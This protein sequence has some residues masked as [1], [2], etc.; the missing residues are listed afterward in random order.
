M[1]RRDQRDRANHPLHR[2][3]LLKYAVAVL[4]AAVVCI[5]N[6]RMQQRRI[7]ASLFIALAFTILLIRYLPPRVALHDIGDP[8]DQQVLSGFRAAEPIDG[9]LGRRTNGPA[10]I[11][12]PLADGRGAARMALQLRSGAASTDRVQLRFGATPLTV[13][14]PPT[15]RTLYLALPPRAARTFD[16]ELR[17]VPGAPPLDVLVDRVIVWGRGGVPPAL[18]LVALALIALVPGLGVALAARLSLDWALLPGVITIA[19]ALALPAADR[20]ALLLFGPFFTVVVAIAAVLPLPRA[21]PAITLVA[22]GGALLR[23]YALGWGNGYVFHAGEQDFVQA[24]PDVVAR[25]ARSLAALAVWLSGANSWQAAWG[26]ALIGRV[27]SALLGTALIVAVYGLGRALLR[28]RWALLA[29]G[30]TAV[31]PL[32][33]QQSHAATS[34]QWDALLIT[35][36]VLGCTRVV[37]GGGV[38]ALAL[39]G[40]ATLLVALTTAQPLPWLVAPGIALVGVQHT[41]RL[42][43]WATALAIGLVLLSGLR[44]FLAG[45]FAPATALASVLDQTAPWQPITV[46][47]SVYALFNMLAW[48][49]GP[50]LMQLGLVGWGVGIVQ[51]VSPAARTARW[52]R[53]ARLPERAWLPLLAA[54]AVALL[55]VGRDPERQ[56]GGLVALAALLCVP[57][58]LLLQTFA[59]RLS[60]RLGQRVVRILAHTALLLA[61]VVAVGLLNIYREPDARIAAS[62]WL[63]YNTSPGQQVLHDPSVRERLPLELPQLWPTVTLPPT[64]AAERAQLV[65]LLYATNYIVL[66]VDRADLDLPTLRQRDPLRACYY[67]ALFDGRLGFTLRAGYVPMPHIGA[68]SF[69]DRRTAAA[70]RVDDHQRV[71]IWE[72]FTYPTRQALDL[73]LN[74]APAL[75]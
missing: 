69:D 34:T 3:I 51:W 37:L 5:Y 27:L 16:L 71:Y 23:G 19:L 30:F 44:W 56:V 13:A 47:S 52:G 43:A 54:L 28:P 24:A 9:A 45:S 4:P 74:C 6:A 64:G 25:A 20:P 68:W 31:A 36:L 75:P 41:R 59:L 63:I 2:C 12:L 67:Q 8:L 29:A 1:L 73:V 66:A 18:D 53:A 17:A 46:P 7:A 10:L 39:T 55:V 72:R 21:Y 11:R 70:L 62:R 42:M 49:L 14:A 65:D 57:A 50:L 48:G 33:V 61:L 15:L 40:G 26:V 60:Y 32:L 35:L 38:R 22:L 58:A